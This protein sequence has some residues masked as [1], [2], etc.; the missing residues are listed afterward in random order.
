[1]RMQ[2]EKTREQME[3][4][5]HEYQQNLETYRVNLV[6][7]TIVNKFVIIIFVLKDF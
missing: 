4:T 5:L 3:Q 6:G 2:A 7:N 1:M